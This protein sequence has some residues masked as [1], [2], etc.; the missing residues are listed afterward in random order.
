MTAL[1]RRGP[2]LRFFILTWILIA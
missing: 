1:S 2:M